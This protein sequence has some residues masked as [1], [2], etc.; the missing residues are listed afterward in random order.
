M[1]ARNVRLATKLRLKQR[2]GQV[3]LQHYLGLLWRWSWLI[4]L[5]AFL[6]AQTATMLLAASDPVY[7]ASTT[8][9]ISQAPVAGVALDFNALRASE[10]LARTYVELLRQRPVMEAVSNNL[11]LGIDADRLANKVSID[12]IPNTQLIQLT[13]EDSNPQRA[14]DIATE[15]VS[16]FGMQNQERQARR[17]AASKGNL[18]EELA[19]IQTEISVA[20]AELESFSGTTAPDE[21][22]KQNQLQAL[23]AQYSSSYATVLNSFEAVRLAEAQTT[24]NLEVVEPAEPAAIS[25]QL[26]NTGKVILAAVLAALVVFG[27]IVLVDYFDDSV[28]SSQEVES[29]VGVETL[30]AIG[31]ILGSSEP[32]KLIPITQARSGLAEAY[33]LLRTNIEFMTDDKPFHSITITSSEPLEGKSL[34]TANLAIV[35]AQTGKR[36]ILVD[37]NLRRPTLHEFFGKSNHRGVTTFLLQS[38]DGLITDYLL[39]TGVDNLRLLSAGPSSTNPAELIGSKRMGDLVEALKAQADIVLFDSPSL[40][41]AVDAMLLARLCDASLLV[42]LA[43]VTRADALRKAKSRL[44]QTG[45][46]IL[47]VVLNSVK[48]SQKNSY[49]SYYLS[50][51]QRKRNVL[52]PLWTR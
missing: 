49:P 11:Q 21:L 41:V 34:T 8:L 29:L 30:A 3:L 10:S 1:G 12:L 19:R 4:A 46:P 50:E 5:S 36:V 20:Q 16:V 43:R 13:V 6:A 7:S 28:R 44:A 9:L 38:G 45:T 31:R 23:I 40:L 51:G 15:I 18:E 27:L 52:Q 32:N 26:D 48:T 17:Y 35:L 24:S 25:A 42:V 14:A 33:R 22:A 2:I 47:G 37:T 39:P